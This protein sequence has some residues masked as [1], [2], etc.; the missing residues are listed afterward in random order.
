LACA[1]AAVAI[2]AAAMV[3]TAAEMIRTDLRIKFSE[4]KGLKKRIGEGGVG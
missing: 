1:N 2:A 4:V 3:A